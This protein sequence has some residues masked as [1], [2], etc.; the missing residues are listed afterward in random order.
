MKIAHGA[1]IEKEA[2]NNG[3]KAEK[4]IHKRPKRICNDKEYNYNTNGNTQQLRIYKIINEGN[5]YNI[6][7]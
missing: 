2:E 3:Y 5:V 7:S 1:K 4:S 6:D